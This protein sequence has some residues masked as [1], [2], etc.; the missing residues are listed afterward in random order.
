MK[1]VIR[2]GATNDKS[3][4]ELTKDITTRFPDYSEGRAKTIAYN[5][6]KQADGYASNQLMNDVAPGMQKRWV[7]MFQNSR[8]AHMDADGQTVDVD[9]PFEVGGEEMDY[10]GG[11]DDPENNINC[12]CEIEYVPRGSE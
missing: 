9:E 8:D 7:C 2:E 6:I 5:E 10:P 3:I 12:Q 11:G 4:E 1:A